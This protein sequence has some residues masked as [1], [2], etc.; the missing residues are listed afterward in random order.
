MADGAVFVLDIYEKLE[1]LLNGSEDII[2]FLQKGL[3]IVKYKLSFMFLFLK[4]KLFK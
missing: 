4:S 1:T 3:S 2:Y